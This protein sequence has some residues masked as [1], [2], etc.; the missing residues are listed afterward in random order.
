MFFSE[1][2]ILAALRSVY[3]MA[4]TPRTCPSVGVGLSASKETD[5][6]EQGII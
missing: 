3:D 5:S 2:G 1:R 4:H 6:P